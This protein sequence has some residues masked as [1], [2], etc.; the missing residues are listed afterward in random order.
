MAASV[1]E[2]LVARAFALSCVSSPAPLLAHEG[3]HAE[4]AALDARLAKSPDDVDLLLPRGAT[5]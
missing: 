4:I 2:P 1:K 3:A 5:W